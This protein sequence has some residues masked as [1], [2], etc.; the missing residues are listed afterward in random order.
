V[1]GTD[2]QALIIEVLDDGSTLRVVHLDFVPQKVLVNDRWDFIVVHGCEYVQGKRKYRFAVFNI[3]GMPVKSVRFSSPVAHWL[4][5]T[6]SRGFDFIIF[7]S[8]QARL[9]AFE[10]FFLE[11]CAPI[12]S[13]KCDFAFLG[14]VKKSNVIIAVASFACTRS[15]SFDCRSVFACATDPETILVL[16]LVFLFNAKI[17]RGLHGYLWQFR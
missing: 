3:N 13:C 8:E 7:S 9:F 10:V 5:V 1:L 15:F 16:L 2:D 4:T 6:S 14:F 12:Y 17:L 11:F